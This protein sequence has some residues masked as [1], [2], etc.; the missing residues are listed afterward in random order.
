MKAFGNFKEAVNRN[1]LLEG[2]HPEGLEALFQ[3]AYHNTYTEIAD[4]PKQLTLLQKQFQQRLRIFVTA[5]KYQAHVLEAQAY[6]C[7]RDLVDLYTNTRQ[8]RS[9]EDAMMAREFFKWMIQQVYEQGE[10]YFPALGNGSQEAEQVAEGALLPACIPASSAHS[11]QTPRYNS[12]SRK[13]ASVSAMSALTS[14]C[15]RLVPGT[16]SGF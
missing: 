13:Y 2:N 5:N 10:Q 9:H 14:K 15:W 6:C 4:A 11:S 8:N 16:A 1:I 3:F 7:I 12:T